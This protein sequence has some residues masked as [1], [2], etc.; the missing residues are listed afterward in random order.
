MK[1]IPRIILLLNIVVPAGC[2]TRTMTVA[3]VGGM[4]DTAIREYVFTDHLLSAG[5]LEKLLEQCDVIIAND[6]CGSN[7]D[8]NYMLK[9]CVL[10]ELGR[11]GDAMAAYGSWAQIKG[12]GHPLRY[13][14]IGYKELISGDS[15]NARSAF[16]SAVSACDSMLDG[17]V[18]PDVVMMKAEALGFLKENESVRECLETGV[19]SFPDNDY[20]A[21][22]RDNADSYIYMNNMWIEMYKKLIPIDE[23]RRKYKFSPQGHL[24]SYLM[25]TDKYDL[26]GGAEASYEETETF[27]DTVYVSVD[28]LITKIT[29]DFYYIYNKHVN[30][31]KSNMT[32]EVNR[33]WRNGIAL[34]RELYMNPDEMGY[35]MTYGQM[36]EFLSWVVESLPDS[37]VRLIGGIVPCNYCVTGINAVEDRNRYAEKYGYPLIADN[38]RFAG[39]I[40]DS[41]LVHDVDSIMKPYNLK[42]GSVTMEKAQ[43]IDRDFFESVNA[44][45]DGVGL[46]E[47]AAMGGGARLGLVRIGRGGSDR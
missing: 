36:M 28:T 11:Y 26:M 23:A 33:N 19:R 25:S 6:T 29:N 43:W 12:A 38:D 5:E 45:V 10:E 22:F 31:V 7:A 15:V 17:A 4:R 13:M 40:K 35:D 3:E 27:V 1:L 44:P 16:L 47:T 46:P 41:R 37:C 32:I 42:V 14:S 20:I 8:I 2:S 30:G 21:A 18:T 24:V 9:I 34:V 39:I